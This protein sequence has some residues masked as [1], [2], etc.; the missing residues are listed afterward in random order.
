MRVSGVENGCVTDGQAKDS[1]FI[2]DL[3]TSVN[4]NTNKTDITCVNAARR[5]G[6][7]QILLY[8]QAVLPMLTSMLRIQMLKCFLYYCYYRN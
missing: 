8:V 4:I 6:M 1:V 5:I 2:I 7:L 3:S